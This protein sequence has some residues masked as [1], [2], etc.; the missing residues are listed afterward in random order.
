MLVQELPFTFEPEGTG[1]PRSEGLHQST[2]I[3]SIMQKVYPKRFK[4]AKATD[5]L[6]WEKFALGWAWEE[7]LSRS[8]AELADVVMHP[9]ELELDGIIG[10]PDGLN[11]TGDGCLEEYKATYISAR[12]EIKSDKFLHWHMQTKGYLKMLGIQPVVI[13]RV[14]FVCGD[15]QYPIGPL[16]KSWRVEFEQHDIETNWQLL[17]RHATNE[18]WL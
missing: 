12:N 16:W 8:F 17:V 7:S 3:K 10:T 4:E 13:Y 14:F 2:I 1:G 9:G 6:P 15:Y 11:V 5:D 18:G